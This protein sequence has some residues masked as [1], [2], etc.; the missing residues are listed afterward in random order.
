[1]WLGLI[2]TLF[3]SR[4]SHLGI[5]DELQQDAV[6]QEQAHGVL[7]PVQNDASLTSFQKSLR[8]IARQYPISPPS[9]DTYPIKPFLL[10][11]VTSRVT[12][13]ELRQAIRSTWASI[14]S[15]VCGVRVLFMIGKWWCGVV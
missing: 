12:G 14:A 11:I 3:R 2:V 1:M 13:F 15:P 8:S 4:G 9:C 5:W 7:A 6:Q 10:V